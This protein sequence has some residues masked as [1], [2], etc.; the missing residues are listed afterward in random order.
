MKH[1][2]RDRK[3]GWK[4]QC[5]KREMEHLMRRSAVATA[6]WLVGVGWPWG[7]IA[8]SIGMN[9]VTLRSWARSWE[10]RR[11]API[12]V[13]RPTVDSCQWLRQQIL[14]VLGLVGAEIGVPTLQEMF[15]EA[16]RRELEDLHARYQ[17]VHKRKGMAVIHALRWIYPG[18]VWAMDFTTPPVPID[19][20]YP[21]VLLVRDLASGRQLL[22]LPVEEATADA[23]VKALSRLLTQFESPLIMKCDNG[24]HFTAGEVRQLLNERGILQLFSPPYTPQYNGACEAGVGSLETR[25]HHEAARHDRVGDWTCD[26]VEAA[27]RQANETARPHGLHGP[28]PDDLWARREPFSALDREYVRLTVARLVDAVRAQRG[29]LP[30]IDLS[31]PQQESINR[32]AIGLACVE[33]GLVLIRRK[34]IPVRV[35]RWRVRRV[36]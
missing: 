28:T 7:R 29:L 20:K 3:R 8:E 18:A 33:L 26:D 1:G 16:A 23:V 12:P 25:A 13:G 14:A 31:E 30:G 11:L 2:P 10:A 36:S 19:G 24:S 34:R 27:R 22:A 17:Q 21:H 32:V 5:V 4:G 6:T 9:E 15:P 35:K